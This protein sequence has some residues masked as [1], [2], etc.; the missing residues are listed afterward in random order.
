MPR[1]N[2]R[3]GKVGGWLSTT[4]MGVQA[5]VEENRAPCCHLQM[6]CL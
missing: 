6:N 4:E 2:V 3:L 5:T 1:F